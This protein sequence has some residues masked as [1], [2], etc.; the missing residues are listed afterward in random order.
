M[1]AAVLGVR[2]R[3]QHEQN[4]ENA[5]NVAEH[6]EHPV[7]FDVLRLISG[8]NE[9]LL[10]VG[11]LLILLL[12][13]ALIGLLVLLLRRELLVLRRRLLEIG[14]LVGLLRRRLLEIRRLVL[15]LLLFGRWRG[16]LTHR[17]AAHRA[18]AGIIGHRSAAVVAYCHVVQ[19]P[20][21]HTCA[22]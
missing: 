14:L 19:P 7:L 20:F 16:D 3:D 12:V 2:L 9:A 5:G 8:R 21:F 22:W 4:A 11:L 6:A 15:R 13:L 17:G 10:L 18:E 1:E